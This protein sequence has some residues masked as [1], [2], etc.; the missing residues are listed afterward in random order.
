MLH[1]E[2]QDEPA[3]MQACILK[4]TLTPGFGRQVL[5][6]L[7]RRYWKAK[8]LAD[9]AERVERETRDR[10]NQVP[11]STLEATQGQI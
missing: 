9:E 5:D 4:T 1:R 10:D 8:T 3:W 6:M 7:E 2:P 11:P